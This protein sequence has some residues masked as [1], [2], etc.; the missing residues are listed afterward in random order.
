MLR[1]TRVTSSLAAMIA[2]A[3]LAVTPAG[4]A[5]RRKPTFG[6]AEPGKPFSGGFRMEGAPK[7]DDLFGDTIAFTQKVDR[8]L[9]LHE[10]MMR[11][12]DQFSRSVQNV[13]I[14]LAT[15]H[16]A[17]KPRTCPEDA[18]A[19][20]YARSFHLGQDFQRSGAELDRLWNE[21]R[22][23]DKL[24]ETGG[25]T[26]DYRWKVKRALSLHKEVLVDWNEMKASFHEHLAKELEFL[27]CDVTALME[28]GEAAGAD[29]LTAPEPVPA[30]PATPAPKKPPKKGES[31]APPPIALAAQFTVDNV[32]C[33]EPMRLYLDGQLV[34]A[35]A[36]KLSKSFSTL[37]GPHDLCLIPDSSPARCGDLGTIRR[38]YIHQG[39]TIQL[40]CSP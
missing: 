2:I 23:L 9:T 16:P 20:G 22:D 1:R 27:G 13:L 24:G 33:D 3:G 25:L 37:V 19:I 26:P 7:V 11:V 17:G 5:P 18:I 32:S 30:L 10:A 40:R 29:I 28:K 31:D 35:V 36:G 6:K 14:A 12:R 21:I 38:T 39:W 34:G 4:S 15:A 8:Y